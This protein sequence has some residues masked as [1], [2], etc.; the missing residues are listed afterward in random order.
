MAVTVTVYQ[1]TWFDV[2]MVFGMEL[3]VVGGWC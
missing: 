2:A 3:W 1:F